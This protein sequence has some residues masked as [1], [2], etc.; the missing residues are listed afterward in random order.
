MCLT[1]FSGWFKGKPQRHHLF[2][3]K[4]QGN[5]RRD[6]TGGKLLETRETT[7]CLSNPR[8]GKTQR[9]LRLQRDGG[10][11]PITPELEGEVVAAGVRAWRRMRRLKH[12]IGG[13]CQIKNSSQLVQ[14]VVL[15]LEICRVSVAKACEPQVVQPDMSGFPVGPQKAVHKET[16]QHEG[17]P[18][19]VVFPVAFLKTNKHRYTFKPHTNTYMVLKIL[20]P[21]SQL[22]S[23]SEKNRIGTLCG[24]DHF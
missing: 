11:G 14:D 15:Q 17:T 18:N 23:D 4:S 7:F 5:H 6:T 8:V 21:S 24:E 3:C 9:G 1:L 2:P 10:H 12:E 19:K 20:E 13:L 16:R 22:F